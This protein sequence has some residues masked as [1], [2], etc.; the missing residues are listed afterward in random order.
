MVDDDEDILMLMRVL[1]TSNNF[2]VV[3]AK[4]GTIGLE[5]VI[6]E[7]PDLVLLDID[8]PEMNGFEVLERIKGNPVTKSI[9]VLMLT[10]RSG[11][12][13]FER[14]INGDADRYVAKPFKSK[15]LLEKINQLL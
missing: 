4:N 2:E 11:G 13:D 7:K 9:P 8:M 1:L 3:T 15:F 10:A 6:S 5:K 14:A 12:A